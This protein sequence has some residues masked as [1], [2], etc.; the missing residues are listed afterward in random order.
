VSDDRLKRAFMES[1]LA[2]DAYEETPA[3]LRKLREDGLKTA[4]LSNGSPFMLQRVM[5]I[6]R[7]QQPD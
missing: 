5:E 4:I 7:Y 3:V 6:C 2:L 1:Y